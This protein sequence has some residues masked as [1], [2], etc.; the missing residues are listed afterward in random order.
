M[1]IELP[2]TGCNILQ[3]STTFYHYSSDNL[4]RETYIIFDGV[5]HLQRTE[6]TQY[7]YAHSG[8]CLT[9]GDLVYKPEYKEE[10]Y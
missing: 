2:T 10:G 7:P 1:D 8:T 6:T 3:S 9:T 4:T 5:A